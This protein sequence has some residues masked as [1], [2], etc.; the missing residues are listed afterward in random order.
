MC[1]R[2][3]ALGGTFQLPGLQKYL[4]QN[5]QLEVLRVDQFSAGGP[6]EAKQRAAFDENLLSLALSL[7]HI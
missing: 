1:I 7:I 3:R 2:D 4:Q 6:A 5:L